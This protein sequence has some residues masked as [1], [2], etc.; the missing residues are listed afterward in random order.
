VIR[1][2]LDSFL[3]VLK[4]IEAKKAKEGIGE[5]RGLHTP[6]AEGG[7]RVAKDMATLPIDY[8]KVN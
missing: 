7:R 3:N 4:A 2:V 1:E 8:K 5:M 6:S